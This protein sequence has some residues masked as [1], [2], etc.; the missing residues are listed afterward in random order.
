MNRLIIIG[1]GGHGK[2]LADIAVKNGYTDIF[3][4][5]DNARGNCMGFEIIGTCDNLTSLNNGAS[6][7]VIG[8]GNNA[9]RKKISEKYDVN[10]I[11][12]IHPSAQ[13][14]TNVSVGRGSVVMAGA[15]VNP[16]TSIGEDCI[17]N[18][19]AVVEHDNVIDNYVHI[20]PNATL[21]GAVCV[22]EKTHIGI[23]TT[24]INNIDICNSCII[25]AGAVVTK[26]ITD[27]GTYVGV[28]ARKIR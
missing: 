11:S 9:V 20:S 13:I 25:G 4:V 26:N 2:V 18:T 7:F 1:A 8:I 3:F 6:D 27:S 22:G 28:P 17:I 21:G 23:G 24:V 16:C 10:W 12:L 5:D 19:C 14:A 15:V